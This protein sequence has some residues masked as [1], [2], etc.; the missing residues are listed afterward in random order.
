MIETTQAIILTP[1]RAMLLEAMY[2]YEDDYEQICLFT[3]IK[4]IYFLKLLGGPY[5]AVAFERS[6]YGPTSSEAST[7]TKQLSN[8]F[9]VISKSATAR[10]FD[11]L[12]LNYARYP[13]LKSYLDAHLSR[14]QNQI[15]R[16]LNRLLDGYKSAY[17]LEVLATV[18]FIREEHPDYTQEEILAIARQ[19]SKRKAEL[20]QPR[21]VQEAMERLDALAAGEL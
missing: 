15:L 2:R 1:A 3:A 8:D 19:W 10:P 16:R 17:S 7:I 21:F 9:V 20:L 5:Q 13:E 12:S 14:E 4:L 6:V 11:S 18:A